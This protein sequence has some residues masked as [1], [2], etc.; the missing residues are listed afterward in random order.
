MCTN[1]A[2]AEVVVK[3][4]TRVHGR[5]R[6]LIADKKN[7]MEDIPESMVFGAGLQ[8]SQYKRRYGGFPGSGTNVISHL[9]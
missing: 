5:G 2:L 7:K 9:V 3:R 8:I 4:V 1:Q 6:T